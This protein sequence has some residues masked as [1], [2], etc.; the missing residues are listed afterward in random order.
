MARLTQLK[1]LSVVLIALSSHLIA[2]EAQEEGG[3]ELQF[4]ARGIIQAVE[5]QSAPEP[6]ED[7]D[8][9]PTGGDAVPEEAPQEKAPREVSF[10]VQMINFD[11][12]SA[13]LTT[14]A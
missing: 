3:E 8:D 13:Q 14:T 1:F 12:D 11:Y 5:E 9:G 4:K 6:V 2:Q 10:D 7:Y